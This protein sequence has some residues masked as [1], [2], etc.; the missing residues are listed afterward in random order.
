MRARNRPLRGLLLLGVAIPACAVTTSTNTADGALGQDVPTDA[1]SPDVPSD[2]PRD[3][4]AATDVPLVFEDLPG[5]VPADDAGTCR[6]E[7]PARS[8]VCPATTCGNGVRDRCMQCNPCGRGGPGIDAG[9]PPPWDAG[10]CCTEV[11]EACDGAD[12]G[13]VTCASLGYRGGVLGCDGACGHDTRA[14]DA[15]ADPEARGVCGRAEVTSLNAQ[16]LALAVRGDRVALA[17]V[18]GTTHVGVALFDRALNVVRSTPCAGFAGARRVALTATRAGFLLAVETAG[19]VRLN[20]LNPDGTLAA[21]GATITDGY[22]PLLAPGPAG[23]ALL[24]YTVGVTTRAVRASPEGAVTRTQATLFTDVTEPEYGS[25]T[26]AGDGWL[27]A[28]RVRGVEVVRVGLDLS[29]GAPQR[30]AGSDTEYPQVVGSGTR[31]AMT[32]ADFGGATLAVHLAELSPAGALAGPVRTFASPLSSS[33]YFNVAPVAAVGED[34]AVLLGTH[35]GRTGASGR[36]DLV[37]ENA[38]PLMRVTTPRP[39]TRSPEAATHY[40]VAALES[41]AVVAWIGEGTPRRIGLA[42]LTP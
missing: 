11:T 8:A 3:D 24:V 21:Q 9:P 26:L 39:V 10:V 29:V 34:L 28:M 13:A 1:V 6:V 41:T 33:R 37:R 27:V 32:W 2:V 19:G 4:R 17:W 16:D 35:T 18:E 30:P 42:R 25:A 23:D 15:C 36:L 22:A 20:P 38:L 5:D 12:L 40:R 7:P 14:C 31:A